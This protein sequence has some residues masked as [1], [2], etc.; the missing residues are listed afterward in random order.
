M[1]VL[2]ADRVAGRSQPQGAAGLGS[3]LYEPINWDE[4]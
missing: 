2:R 3:P 1:C 4:P